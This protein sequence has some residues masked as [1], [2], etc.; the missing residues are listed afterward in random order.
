MAIPFK[1]ATWRLFKRDSDSEIPTQDQGSSTSSKNYVSWHFHYS[2][3]GFL[4][5]A[6]LLFSKDPKDKQNVVSIDQFWKRRLFKEDTRSK[7]A[8]DPVSVELSFM[9]FKCYVRY[10][11]TLYYR[12]YQNKVRFQYIPHYYTSLLDDIQKWQWGNKKLSFLT[13]KTGVVATT[14]RDV[15]KILLPFA[16]FFRSS[17]L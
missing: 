4:K 11:G 17:W 16:Q 2:W 10:K 6:W 5:H 1:R 7:K 15:S 14:W 3:L 13:P 8:I 9:L 12:Y